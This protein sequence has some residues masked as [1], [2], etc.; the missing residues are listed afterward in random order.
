MCEIQNTGKTPVKNE[1]EKFLQIKQYIM[2]Y[3]YRFFTECI[4][5]L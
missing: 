1:Y 2:P 4:K 3:F 5:I